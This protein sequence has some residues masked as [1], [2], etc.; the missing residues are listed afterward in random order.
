M[1]TRKL[2]S[3]LLAILFLFSVC[4][5]AAAAHI[6]TVTFSDW[7]L[8]PEHALPAWGCANDCKISGIFAN[9]CAFRCQKTITDRARFLRLNHS[10]SMMESQYLFL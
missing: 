10:I 8:L 1:K 4:L 6:K 5:P 7:R 3:V 2:T 9:R